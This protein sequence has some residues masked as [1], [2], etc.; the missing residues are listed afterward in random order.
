MSGESGGTGVGPAVLSLVTGQV[1]RFLP[2]LRVGNLDDR[3]PDAIRELLPGLWLVI[4]AWYR[5]DV[6]GLHHIPPKGPALIVGNHTG[7][8]LS[9]EVLISQLAV[10]SYFGAQRPFYQLAHRMVLNSPLAPILR[11]FGTVEADPDNGHAVLSEGGLLQVFPGGDY[12]CYRPSSQSALIDFDHRKGF[13]RLALQHDV[14]IVPQVTIGGQETA[15][16]LT[17]GDSLARFLGLDRTMRLKVLPIVL[18]A[19]FG[20]TLPFGPF[21]PLPAKI[22]ISYLPP[23]DLRATYGDDPDLDKVYDDVVGRMQDVLT[24]LQAERKLPVLG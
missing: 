18:S 8:I 24:A 4:S 7:G 9:P 16:F 13:L 11:R 14:P 3:D 10:T 17:R 20:V 15:L 6:R 19:P 22:T 5:P 2:R 1:K 21:L 23:I 12:E